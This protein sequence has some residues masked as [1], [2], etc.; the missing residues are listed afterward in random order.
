[1]PWVVE[2]RHYTD[3]QGLCIFNDRLDFLDGVDL[4]GSEGTVEGK[5]WERLKFPWETIIISYMP[6]EDIEL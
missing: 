6:M 4:V 1:M 2:F 3:C 5:V